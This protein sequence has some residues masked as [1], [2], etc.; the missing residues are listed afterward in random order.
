MGRVGEWAC[1]VLCFFMLSFLLSFLLSRPA[2]GRAQEAGDTLSVEDEP[3]VEDGLSDED[4][5]APADM[6]GDGAEECV[7]VGADDLI[8]LNFEGAD[9]RE[10]IQGLAAGLC[11][12]YSIDPRVQGAVTLRTASKIRGQDLFPLFHQIMRINGIAAVK[13]GDIYHIAPVGEAKTKVPLLSESSGR[14]TTAST[15]DEFVIEL[16]KLE[17]MAATAMTEILQPFVSPGGDVVAYPR[18]NLVILTDLASNVERLRDLIAA[19]DTDTFR[20]LHTQI[21]RIEHANVE[22]L[23][24]ELA[25]I[26]QPY[27]V[28]PENAEE[29]GLYIIPLTRL[30][31]I[32]VFGF[33]EEIFSQIEKWIRVLDVPPEKGGGRTVYVYAVENSKA[34]DLADVLG[35]LYGSGGG[36]RSRSGR[37]REGG[38]DANQSDSD[39]GTGLGSSGGLGGRGSRRSGSSSIVIEP[40]EGEP[41][42]FK[43]VVRIVADEISNSLIILATPRDYDKIREVLVRID[44]VPRQVLIEAIIAEISLTGNLQFGIEYA[45]ATGGIDNILGTGEGGS[46]NSLLQTGAKKAVN[47]SKNGIFSFITD[48][49]NFISMINAINTRS[50]V[51]VLATPHV[52]AA[53][54][55]EAHILIGTEVPILTSTQQSTLATANIVS[56]IQYRDTGTI[57]TILPQVNSAGLVNMEIRQEVSNVGVASFGDTNSPSFTSRETETT[58]VVRNRESVLIGGIIDERI[59]RSRNGVPFLMDVPVLGRLFRVEQDK[60]ERTE[61]VILITPYVIRDRNEAQVMTKEFTQRVHRLREMIESARPSADRKPDAAQP[62]AGEE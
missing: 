23:G 16:I 54:N 57:L 31:A 53:D 2:P 36:G 37:D 5:P 9:I 58:V 8:E 40:V 13:V 11:I 26:L 6:A 59:E 22:D 62:D 7:P 45:F 28:I 43:E 46:S 38:Q 3:F 60:R 15:Q 4:D 49:D 55:R 18:G 42:L 48:Q 32:V 17:H 25:S 14:R 30:N 56:S 24:K 41:P 33:N 12:H 39:S 29:R 21:Y 52:I 27:G 1:L 19:F 51:N 44:V 47:V 61:L 20:T 10:V 34:A 35:D 50:R